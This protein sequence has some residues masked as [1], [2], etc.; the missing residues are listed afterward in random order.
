MTKIKNINGSFG[1]NN[2]KM[3]L[4]TESTD[5]ELNA[6]HPS[7]SRFK[8][9]SITQS[10]EKRN[11]P[12]EQSVYSFLHNRE[13]R[14]MNRFI[15]FLTKKGEKAIAQKLFYSSLK[16][17]LQLV[18]K[19]LDPALNTT[20]SRSIE[21]TSSNSMKGTGTFNRCKA[22]SRSNISDVTNAQINRSTQ[23]IQDVDSIDRLLDFSQSGSNYSF[24]VNYSEQSRIFNIFND[25]ITNI[26]PLFEVKKVRIAGTTYQ[27]P[28][29]IPQKRQESK[30]INWVIESSRLRKKKET[31]KTFQDCLA[32]E[33]YEA[34][35]KQG[36]C[37]QKR[38]EAH[39][40]AETN[41]AFSHYRWW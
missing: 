28:A 32:Q 18:N 34:Y 31:L 12:K 11:I 16:I 20:Y 8:I 5:R 9:Y 33:L 13:T 4:V 36:A 22:F 21:S 3:N 23:S 17:L 15:N 41:R 40:I 37:R 10:L 14:L 27:V 6:S 39:K 7:I 19:S 38:T 29:L 35:M 1:E 2:L 24:D 26:K 30:A 25:A